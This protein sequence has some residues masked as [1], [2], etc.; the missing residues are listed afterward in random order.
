MRTN[1]VCDTIDKISGNK[2]YVHAACNPLSMTVIPVKE[3]C[4]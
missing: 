3:E 2:L 1:D 4:S